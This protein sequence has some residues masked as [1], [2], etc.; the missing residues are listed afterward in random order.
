[1]IFG[2]PPIVTDQLML[3]FDFA[4]HNQKY[5]IVNASTWISGS[6]YLSSF[7]R[8][9]TE[10]ENVR[11]YDS[12]PWSNTALIWKSNT[13]ETSDSDGGWTC[14]VV[15]IDPNKTHR[16]SVWIK[17]NPIGNGYSYLGVAGYS[18]G[19]SIGVAYKS[20]APIIQMPYT[21][22]PDN[23]VIVSSDTHSLTQGQQVHF[24]T[25]SG[26]VLPGG[27]ATS[28]TYYVMSCSID[29]FKISTTTAGYPVLDITSAGTGSNYFDGK[30]NSNAYCHARQW[31]P[32]LENVWYLYVGH[33]WAVGSETGSPHEDSG[34]WSIDGTKLVVATDFMFRA[35]INGTV[36]R[37]YLYYSTDTSTTQYF[38]DPRIDVCDGTEPTLSELLNN[39][40]Y[41]V[42]DKSGRNN[43]GT[44]VDFPSIDSLN[45]GCLKLDGIKNKVVCNYIPFEANTTW[46]AWVNRITSVNDYNMIMGQYLPYF[47]FNS[48]NEIHFSNRIGSDQQSIYSPVIT[49]PDGK[50]YHLTF[51][52]NY[53]GANTTMTIFINGV[54]VVSGTFAGVMVP[55]DAYKFTIGNW[56]NTDSYYYLFNGYIEGVK[57]YNKTLSNAEIMQNFNASKV[58]FLK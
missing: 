43:H 5:G 44:M 28:R 37:S 57:L 53:D 3:Y 41:K 52:T 17:R 19:N 45:G 46:E 4:R 48:R 56:V 40:P 20:I 14:P 25:G 23:D 12:D 26:G 54:P 42:S 11:D 36:H 29:A 58:R 6:T 18:G 1:M 38:F 33:V 22:D 16:F 51:T 10:A 24:Y 34:V 30:V 35:M 15:R 21:A 39:N 8:N 31:S 27:I 50:W 13:D 9:G 7:P 47:A 2:A 32:L 49:S 55:N